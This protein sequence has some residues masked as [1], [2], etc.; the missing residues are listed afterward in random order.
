[1]KTTIVLIFV[2]VLMGTS[3][4]ALTY[5]SKGSS[6][7]YYVNQLNSWSSNRQGTGSSPANFTQANLILIVQNGHTM[8]ATAQWD[9]EG[10]GSR[11]EIESGGKIT[12][13]TYNHKITGK[14]YNGGTYEVNH[15]TYSNLGWGG[16]GELETNSTFI[17]NHATINFND[18]VSYGNLTVQAGIAQCD[19]STEG[20]AIKGQLLIKNGTQFKYDVAAIYNDPIT[21]GSIV[22]ETGGWFIGGTGS[23]S[24]TYNVG[25]SIT[26][27][28][29]AY[30]YG[31][32]GS[33]GSTFNISGD[34][35]N[36][37]NFFYV[38]HRNSG[39]LP[40][41]S[42]NVAGS[43]LNYGTYH[44]VNRNQVGYPTITL[45]GTGKS[46]R[47]GTLTGLQAR[48]TI[49][50]ATGS[51]YTLLSDLI[52][53][54]WM[55]FRER[56]TLD[57]GTYQVKA[58]GASVSMGIW[59]NFRTARTQGFSGASNTA[60][61][62]D[63]SPSL[64]LYAG[65]TIEYTSGS[66]QTVTPR[67]DYKHLTL[68]GAGTKSIG[69]NTTIA[70][71][72]TIG[73]PLS[74]SGN[75]TANGNVAVNQPVTI[76]SGNNLYLYSTMSGSSQITGGTIQIL[77]S[78]TQLNL[79]TTDVSNIILNRLNGCAISGTSVKTGLLNIVNGPFSIGSKSLEITN[80]LAGG[81]NL[82][83]T[84]ASTLI[85]SGS[86]LSFNMPGQIT[87]LHTFQL[88]SS[89]GATLHDNLALT[90]LNLQN[91]TFNVGI[92]TLTLYGQISRVSGTLGTTSSS[93]LSIQAG[94]VNTDLPPMTVG[95]L[96]MNR[97]GRT[98]Y[99]TGYL[100][101]GTL[102]LNGGNLA[103]GSN[104]LTITTQISTSGGGFYSGDSSELVLYP[105]VTSATIP[106]VTLSYYGQHCPITVNLSG[107]MNVSVIGLEHGTLN[108]GNHSLTV[109]GD[110]LYEGGSITG[111]VFSGLYLN[112]DNAQVWDIPA[113]N[114]GFL[115][116]SLTGGCRMI[117]NFNVQAT[118]NLQ[119]GAVDPNGN[120]TIANG[121]TINRFAGAFSSSPSL[122]DGLQI[123]YWQT[124]QT[125]Y[126]LPAQ[127]GKIQSIN[128]GDFSTVTASNDVY[129][130]QELIV[131][132]GGVFDLSTYHLYLGEGAIISGNGDLFGA[133]S[134]EIGSEGMDGTPAGFVIIGG[135]QIDNFAF[136]QQPQSQQ[137]QGASGILRTWS[138]SGNPH[139]QFRLVLMWDEVA[140]NGIIWS[141][142]NRAVVF[143]KTGGHWYQV[144]DPQ[145]V[146]LLFPRRVTVVT[147]GFS[148]WT[149]FPEDRPLP[150]VLSSFTVAVSSGIFV[151]I[152]WT[153]QSESELSGFHI[154]RALSSNLAEA[155]QISPLIAA[156]NTT[157]EHSYAYSD[158]DLENHQTYYYWLECVEMGG[159]INHFG[160]VSVY[161]DFNDGDPGTPDL[162]LTTQLLSS[163]PNP[164]NPNTTISYCISE[165]ASVDLDIFN[166]RGQLIRH[167]TRQH[168]Q[169]GMF[170]LVWDGRDE[171]GTA[172]G[173]GIY[174]CRMTAGKYCST[175]KMILMK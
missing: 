139:D 20:L 24:I 44:A 166:V 15:D 145:D 75:I 82:S 7:T 150:V 94:H 109:T 57:A 71:T 122:G 119:V 107:S 36:N 40:S 144:G 62:T 113:S 154:L 121:A 173:S 6:P 61:S 8:T 115:N 16:E 112:S 97:S 48:H 100:E 103:I 19:G 26:V 70:N 66:S 10:S 88:S 51:S 64:T 102:N 56:G 169:T 32:Q 22:V 135:T 43:F 53:Y 172:L 90:N 1:V 156:C 108:L 125:G 21:I 95:T 98:A 38:V 67:T 59:G 168:E 23:P 68:S 124:A 117:G 39:D 83:A 91:G 158:P 86:A 143:R 45:S 17:L 153:T 134:R 73:A 81:A 34:V 69:G 14:V 101:V 89:N 167:F 46:V 162:P 130:S 74:V 47:F 80:E 164:F 136:G 28:S 131:N 85:V 106:A 84:S 170:R 13:G 120:L 55:Q 25:G 132:H 146:S 76:T 159:I 77:G 72:F 30:F 50:F 29:G 42:W 3:L 137:H 9:V 127:A 58:L 78:A 171:Q 12:T 152:D 49:E 126:E 52:F 104:S 31:S 96:T 18:K 138:F 63:N 140:D 110:F 35:T 33:G 149:V 155:V 129:V 148:D 165:P 174:Y 147:D 2:F 54:D 161:V 175:R 105:T 87:E 79:V 41:G 163:Y 118:I 99:Q 123:N 27:N 133:G 4:Y 93:T 65:C 37:S 114:I 128:V 141:P 151:R 157:I 11:V 160:P 116:V 60:I 92:Y 142:E 5:Y 111:S